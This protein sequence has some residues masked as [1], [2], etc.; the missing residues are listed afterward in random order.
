MPPS[1]HEHPFLQSY[2]HTTG[3]RSKITSGRFA[4]S[5]CKYLV[6]IRIPVTV[7][8]ALVRY[9][10][11]YGLNVCLLTYPGNFQPLFLAQKC[12]L[13]IILSVEPRV[14]VA[15]GF[16]LLASYNDYDR[17]RTKISLQALLSPEQ[18]HVVAAQTRRKYIPIYGP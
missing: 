17:L 11:Y 18:H 5:K 15:F 3:V 12:S 4:T 2:P 8:Y 1:L 14:R 13:R 10:V 9:Q 7:Y 16:S 6:P